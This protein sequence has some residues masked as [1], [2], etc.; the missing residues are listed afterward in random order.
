MHEVVVLSGNVVELYEYEKSPIP[1]KKVIKTRSRRV[2]VK[3]R[4]RALRNVKRAKV[5]FRRLVRATLDIG[6][7]AFVTLTMADISDI[8]QAYRDFSLFGGRMRKVFGSSVAWI[9]VPE[10]Q[11]RGAVHFHALIWG[12]PRDVIFNESPFESYIGNR[13]GRA[14]VNFISFCEEH[15]YD[16]H[17]A[18][19]SRALQSLWRRGWCDISPTDGSPKLASYLAKYMLK[20]MRRT[21]SGG[22]KCYLSS[23]NVVRPV[24]TNLRTAIAHIKTQV[25]QPH[26]RKVKRVGVDNYVLARET[27][28]DTQWLGRCNYKMYVREH[29]I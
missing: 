19:G 18:S 25:L 5:Q 23:R 13:R 6:K 14:L 2:E 10:Y 8:G 24:R 28:Y 26:R 12:L 4:P 29:K 9:A 20:E 27:Q 11:A 22:R 1:K 3:G 7:P 15:G 21:G 16:P 17:L